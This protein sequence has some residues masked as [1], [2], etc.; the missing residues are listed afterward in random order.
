MFS[1]LEL[2][3][4]IATDGNGRAEISRTVAESA[5]GHGQSYM[6]NAIDFAFL[7]LPFLTYG[8]RQKDGAIDVTAHFRSIAVEAPDPTTLQDKAVAAYHAF[9]NTLY[10][11][12]RH[13]PARILSVSAI[14]R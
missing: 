13:D 7:S 1:S 6:P 10:A 4:I 8:R 9:C 14:A 2:K 3:A 11:A 5:L 12:V